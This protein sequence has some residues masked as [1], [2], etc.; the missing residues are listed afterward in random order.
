MLFNLILLCFNT[1][2]AGP[3]GSEP[4][5]RWVRLTK[6]ARGIL[7]ST[8]LANAPVVMLAEVQVLL[9]QFLRVR[10]YMHE[11]YK[12]FRAHDP[13]QLHKDYLR[14]TLAR[15]DLMLK[16][17][18]DATTLFNASHYG[19]LS[20]VQKFL[21]KGADVHAL[22]TNERTP[23]FTACENGHVYAAFVPTL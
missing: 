9:S 7:E 20:V 14:T 17:D 12:A 3:D 4:A 21:A 6:E 15:E 2:S 16:G 8:A 1:V 19:Q 10:H 13:V 18:K 11:V 23:L 5:E 22:A